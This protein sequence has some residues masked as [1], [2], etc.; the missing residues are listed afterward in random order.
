M[1]KI[2]LF[3]LLSFTC[4]VFSQGA[5]R[6]SEVTFDYSIYCF[7]ISKKFDQDAFWRP[8]QKRNT[9]D[10][11]FGPQQGE[12]DDKEVA[13]ILKVLEK[14]KLIEQKK[15][16]GLPE[17]TVKL[18]FLDKKSTINFSI[19]QTFGNSFYPRGMN[20]QFVLEV[21]GEPISKFK[22]I[23]FGRYEA[24]SA[25]RKNGALIVSESEYVILAHCKRVP[26][27]VD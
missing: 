11:I 13:N 9:P 10:R 6:K 3:L 1:R 16:S 21:K 26:E 7:K 24:T 23:P 20:V 12:V 25:L 5:S 4:T 19:A 17:E 8:I 2:I 15:V 27:L 22:A 14:E 18:T